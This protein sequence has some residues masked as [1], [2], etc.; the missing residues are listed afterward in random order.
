MIQIRVWMAIFFLSGIN[1]KSTLCQ[2]VFKFIKHLFYF[3]WI[4]CHI[5]HSPGVL[6]FPQLFQVFQDK[7]SDLLNMINTKNSEKNQTLFLRPFS[8]AK[9]QI[10]FESIKKFPRTVS[11]ID[12]S[13]ICFYVKKAPSIVFTGRQK[14]HLVK[15]LLML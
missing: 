12:N 2:I 6:N 10:F 7:I 9:I 15:Y 4:N 1:Y 14:I 3:I 13:I 11:L 5:F 8:F